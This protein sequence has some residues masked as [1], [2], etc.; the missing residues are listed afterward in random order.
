MDFNIGLAESLVNIVRNLVGF[1]F[2]GKVLIILAVSIATFGILDM[3]ME[4]NIAIATMPKMPENHKRQFILSIFTI[5]L[6]VAPIVIAFVWL[7]KVKFTWQGFGILAAVYLIGN[8]GFGG[9]L[10]KTFED[11]DKRRRQGYMTGVALGVFWSLLIPRLAYYIQRF[12]VGIVNLVLE[13]VRTP[14]I[15]NY[16][17]VG[18]IIN[19]ILSV[20]ITQVMGV[21]QMAGE[22]NV[23][24]SLIGGLAHGILRKKRIA[25]LK[26]S[27]NIGPRRREVTHA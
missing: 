24:G 19:L 5:L 4:T 23:V 11:N 18:T 10:K 25:E 16:L 15:L 2:V 14:F 26:A 13:V 8:Y 17:V 12:L 27:L 3:F 1:I 7:F 21:S 6:S 9:S 20:A 22:A